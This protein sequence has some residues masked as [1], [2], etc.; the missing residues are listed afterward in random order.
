MGTPVSTLVLNG[1]HYVLLDRINYN[2]ERE[3]AMEQSLGP[4]TAFIQM[5]RTADSKHRKKW[6]VAVK[7]QMYLVLTT[8]S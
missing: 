6:E 7:A 8:S 5:L 1:A 2:P 4:L 3:T